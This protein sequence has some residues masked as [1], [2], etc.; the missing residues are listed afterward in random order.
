MVKKKQPVERS[1]KKILIVDDHVYLRT[2]IKHVLEN[3]SSKYSYIIDEAESGEEAVEKALLNSYDIILMDYLLPEINGWEASKQ[4]LKKRPE[5]RIMGMSGFNYDATIETISESGISGYVSKTI[6]IED[7]LKAIETIIDG[8]EY[9]S[10][11][12][13]E[14]MKMAE[15]NGGKLPYI[16]PKD[17]LSKPEFEIFKMMVDGFIDQEIAE[18]LEISPRSVE[19]YRTSMMKKLHVETTVQLLKYAVLHH[20]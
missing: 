20:R 5:T 12:I 18:N 15:D 17:L 11:D 7:I 6:G 9:F 8:E 14:R 10:D 3:Y 2:G 19:T 16:N 4:I 13:R 1:A